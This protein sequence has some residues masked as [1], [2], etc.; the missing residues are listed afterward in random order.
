WLPEQ[1]ASVQAVAERVG[2]AAENLRLLGA[3]QRRA[4]H[5]RL[6]AEVTARMRQSLDIDAVLQ[7]GVR[8][9]RQA[10]DIPEVEVRLD[11]AHLPGTQVP[12]LPWTQVPHEGEVEG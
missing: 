5:D 9:M 12:H 2:L 6:L 10:L 1:V 8:E 4:A 7:A 3:A 11:V